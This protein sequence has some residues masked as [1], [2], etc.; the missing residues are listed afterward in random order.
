MSHRKILHAADVHLDSPMR[1][2]E[3]YPDAPVD[4]FRGATRRALAKLV[5]L[6]ISERVDL[7]VIAGDLYDGDWDDAHTG[8]FFAGQ[9]ARLRDAG[10]PIVVLRGNHDAAVLMS[11]TIRLPD[12]PDGS[13]IMLDWK[14]VERREFPSLGVV[15]HGRSFETRAVTE[16]L[17]LAY[18]DAIRGMFNLGVLHTSLTGSEGHETYAPTSPEKLR[19]KGYDYWALGHVHQRRE[20]QA[21]GEPPIVFPGNIQ[22]RHVRETGP[23]GCVILEIDSQNRVTT[24]F[25]PLDVVRWEV[26]HHDASQDRRS[27]DLLDA[28]SHWLDESLIA[29]ESR[30]LAVR[31]RVGGMTPLHESYH[32]EAAALE[33]ELHAIAVQRGSDRVWIERLRI[34]TSLPKSAGTKSS[35]GD[36]GAYASLSAVL[37]QMRSGEAA[38][39][40][41]P[42]LKPLW[43]KLPRTLVGDPLDPLAPSPERIEGWLDRAAPDL[44]HRLQD[45][46]QSA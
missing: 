31:V 37:D 32:R 38:E 33:N 28:F 1:N 25:H 22:G 21:A 43:D 34:R 35:R 36:E 18:P 2:L 3:A 5:D 8:V 30:P 19:R 29:A 46:E 13:A 40:V 42:L 20:C 6:A 39:S 16:D 23:K 10:I 24:V 45:E 12:N 7:V 27:D 14:S 17:S 26:F 15:V 9:A 11:K 44:L 41:P 4:A